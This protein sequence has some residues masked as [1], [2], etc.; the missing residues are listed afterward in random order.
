MK[1]TRP[2]VVAGA[3]AAVAASLVGVTAAPA[4]ASTRITN[5]A[6]LTAS[7]SQ[8]VAQ[9]NTV[10]GPGISCCP[11]GFVSASSTYVPAM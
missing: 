5:K 10:S 1:H 7:I 9:A 4:S 6:E 8:A 3:T 11:Q 2:I